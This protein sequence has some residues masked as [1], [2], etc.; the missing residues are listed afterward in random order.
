MQEYIDL[1]VSDILCGYLKVIF[2][3]DAMNVVFTSSKFVKL[4]MKLNEMELQQT[5]ENI[6]AFEFRHE[7]WNLKSKQRLSTS[8][9]RYCS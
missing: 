7:V 6:W 9:R 1:N 4:H 3:S 2:T 8:L 5:A